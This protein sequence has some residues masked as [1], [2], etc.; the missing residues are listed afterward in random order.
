MATKKSG[1]NRKIGRNAAKC[2]K[3][4]TRHTKEKNK[5]R[6]CL[7]SNGKPYSVVWA[8]SRKANGLS[9]NWSSYA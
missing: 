8:E 2:M 3:Y 1:G 9:A 4:R 7:K 6:R 5:N